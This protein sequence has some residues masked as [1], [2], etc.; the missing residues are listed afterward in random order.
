MGVSRIKIIIP[1]GGLRKFLSQNYPSKWLYWKS[2]LPLQMAMAQNYLFK[3]PSLKITPPIGCLENQN[4]LPKWRAQ[5][6]LTSLCTRIPVSLKTNK[7]L[8]MKL[9]GEVL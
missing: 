2:K 3:F 6:D 5:N 8:I 9:G 7:K 4:Y 1:I